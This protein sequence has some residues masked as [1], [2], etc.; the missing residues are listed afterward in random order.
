MRQAP[1]AAPPPHSQ[2]ECREECQ[3]MKWNTA[4]TWPA[5]HRAVIAALGLAATMASAR[6][7][8]AQ[9]ITPPP[10]PAGIE[11]DAPA[12]AFLL[13]HGVGTQN[14]VCVATTAIGHV[15]WTLFTPQATL[16][17]DA[18]DQLTTHFFSTNPEEAP[19]IRAAW[20]DSRDTSTVWAAA[21]ASSS[22]ANFVAAGAIPW[23]KLEVVG[24]RAG[25]TGGGTLTVTTF[26]QRL[27]TV[28]GAAPP[29]GCEKP[30]DI[31]KRAFVPY[32][33]DYFFY[34]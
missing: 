22:D 6:S 13:G 26:I 17:N 32:E 18:N 9:T 29:D 1:S 12:R 11:V 4:L 23:L 15:A 34:R 31:G 5:R 19:V 3:M 10:V 16:F 7:V 24:R 14:Y 28:G 27:N 33:A 30:G 25:P 2:D 20:Q 21:V 8:Q